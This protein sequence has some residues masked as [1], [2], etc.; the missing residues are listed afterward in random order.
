MSLSAITSSGAAAGQSAPASTQLAKDYQSFLT[1]LVAQ[2]QNQD[3]LAPMESTE[4]VSQLAQLTQVEQSVQV[5]A[6]M[7]S[8]RQQ[9]SMNAALAETSL[10]GLQVTV[11]SEA[12][13]LSDQGGRFWYQL[14]NT[15]TEVTAQILD[16]SGNLVRRIDGLPGTAGEMSEVRW[17]GLSDLG[18]PMPEGRYT[19]AITATDAEGAGSRYNSFASGRVVA[20]D[21]VSGST[22]LQLADGTR[23]MSAEIIRAE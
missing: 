18:E 17:D 20:V 3:P 8:L 13:D 7:E 12:F 16:A 5:N 21:Y 19:I 1:L 2:V 23:V 15:S 22:Y 6:H 10:I 4:F 11:P 9:L 14:E